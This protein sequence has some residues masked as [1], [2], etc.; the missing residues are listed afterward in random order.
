M[1]KL[2]LKTVAVSLV[3]AVFLSFASGVMLIPEVYAS[4]SFS[5]T[6]TTPDGSAVE[7]FGSVTLS[8]NIITITGK[9]GVSFNYTITADGFGT[10]TETVPSDPSYPQTI[11][12]TIPDGVNPASVSVTVNF[13]SAAANTYTVT[14]VAPA[15]GS[16]NFPAGASVTVQTP[17]T[18]PTNGAPFTGWDVSGTAATVPNSATASFTMP[19]GNVTLTPKYGS[20]TIANISVGVSPSGAANVSTS[21]ST[22]NIGTGQTATFTATAVDA[23]NSFSHWQIGSQTFTQNPL[24]INCDDYRG[25]PD[26]HAIAY[27]T[28]DRHKITIQD[29]TGG[30]ATASAASAA[31]GD[32]VKFTADADSGYYFERWYISPSNFPYA[33]TVDLTSS[34]VIITMP[35][36]PVGVQ[37]I[38]ESSAPQTVTTYDLI[39]NSDPGGSI[40]QGIGGKYASGRE[41]SIAA[42]ASEGFV[43]DGWEISGGTIEDETALETTFTMPAKDSSIVAK[44]ISDGTVPEEGEQFPITPGTVTGGQI[45]INPLNASEGTPVTVQAIPDEGYVFVNW[46]SVEGVTFANPGEA[47]TTF[48]MPASGATIT[49]L[50]E[51]AEEESSGLGWLWILLAIL[52]ILGVAGGIIAFVLGKKKSKNDDDQ[53]GGYGG[54]DN[55]YGG[56]Q[57]QGYGSYGSNTGQVGYGTGYVGGQG[58]RARNKGNTQTLEDPYGYNSGQQLDQYGADPYVDPYAGDGQYQDPYA[59]AGQYDENEQYDQQQYSEGYDDGQGYSEDGAYGEGY[60]GG[61]VAGEQEYAEEGS[62]Y[63]DGGFS[64]YDGYDDEE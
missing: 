21:A 19:A 4:G 40:T 29:S 46:N 12:Y 22:Y 5:P 47:S 42:V 18:H 35:D 27:Y 33:D 17:T 16:G 53:Y 60:E 7:N 9:A 55:G 34:T 2:T 15:T 24:T 38:F 50:F 44:F 43:F 52:G 54:Y 56:N 51:L 1:K 61:Y 20:A 58:A 37:A 39:L 59:A 13:N 62:D 25:N 57:Q 64:G 48:T 6:I 28:D 10:K 36:G 63:S 8:G 41:I 31:G 3:L 45:T 32:S 11:T 49:A 30:E 23:N 26:I 14:T